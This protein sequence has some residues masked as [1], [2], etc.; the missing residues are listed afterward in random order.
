MPGRY[1]FSFGWATIRTTTY[2]GGELGSESNPIVISD[3]E[4][5][6]SPS[7]HI[8][9]YCENYDPS[10]HSLSVR[11][12][13]EANTEITY[14]P[15][16]WDG[17]V[18]NIYHDSQH[19][20]LGLDPEAGSRASSLIHPGSEKAPI[21]GQLSLGVLIDGDG[22]GTV[23]SISHEN[24]TEE[25]HV[26][27]RTSPEVSDTVP[28]SQVPPSIYSSPGQ[29]QTITQLSPKEFQVKDVGRTDK[30]EYEMEDEI[31]QLGSPSNPIV[32]RIERM[33][34][35]MKMQQKNN[36]ERPTSNDLQYI[37]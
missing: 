16:F 33:M 9:L 21:V 35:R 36:R 31:A 22:R 5:F 29:S 34:R 6:G 4:P 10:T 18:N 14:T 30:M 3:S 8:V 23:V 28:A 11:P 37:V 7:N 26:E 20:G 2:D 1:Y 24:N 25:R 17:V 15:E 12:S 13:S 19:E 27:Q 32:S